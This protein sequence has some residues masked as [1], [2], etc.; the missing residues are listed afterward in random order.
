LLS[1][2]AQGHAYD[3]S[4]RHSQNASQGG[5]MKIITV[6][7]GQVSA[8]VKVETL[9]LKGAGIDIPV[10]K[11][12]E[13]GR[14]RSLGILPVQLSRASMEDWKEKGSI[15]VFSAEVGSTKKGEPKLLESPNGSEAAAIF[16][17]RTK[18]GFRGGNSHTGD[19]NG[20][21]GYLP[22]PGKIISRGV[23]AQ[24]DA[25][26]MG[27]GDQLIAIIPKGIVFRTAYSGRLYGGPSQHFYVWDGEE[28]LALSK[29]ERELSELF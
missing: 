16:V 21:D 27:D 2:T 20:D 4:K 9:H 6:S 23:I 8:G 7:S 25:G 24:G 14:G 18:I 28:V 12:G 11:I 3:K 1:S 22:F 10:V 5:I 15:N 17:F 26:R 29:E 19:E 13:D